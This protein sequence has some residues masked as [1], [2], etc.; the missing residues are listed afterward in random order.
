MRPNENGGGAPTPTP[1]AIA[2][3]ATAVSYYLAIQPESKLHEQW[4]T[5]PRSLVELGVEAAIGWLDLIDEQA[6]QS[7]K[8]AEAPESAL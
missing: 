6:E 4:L 8:R 5:V 1:D 2:S 7:S 3:V